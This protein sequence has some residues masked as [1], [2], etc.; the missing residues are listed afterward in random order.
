MESNVSAPDESRLLAAVDVRADELA[1]LLRDLVRAPS[2]NPPG[3]T[4]AAAAVARDY[5]A[6]Q[7]VAHQLLGAAPERPSLLAGQPLHATTPA[8]SPRLLFLSH[9]DTVP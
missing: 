4:R 6:R 8:A 1:T 3:D 9:L 7:G 5:L 2:V